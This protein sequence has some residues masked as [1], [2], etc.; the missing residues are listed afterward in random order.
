MGSDSSSDLDSSLSHPP[1]RPSTSAATSPSAAGDS[2]RA[3][4][5][6]TSNFATEHMLTEEKKARAENTR[7]EAKRLAALARSRRKKEEL[8]HSE[9]AQK[10]KELDELL[11]KSSV[12]SDILT[13]KTKALGRV[14]R[15]FDNQTLADAGVELKKQPKIMTG[16][17]M[18]DY[19]LEGLTWMF[20]IML[21]GMSGILADEM[22]LGGFLCYAC[23]RNNTVINNRQAR[24][25]KPFH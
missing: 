25:Y 22:G 6:S 11:R 16:G 24:R 4:M 18:R 8:S 7:N 10:A 2:D 5:G 17:V 13:Q 23:L 21:Q 1:S 12:F 20:E 9:R 19:Q 15:D 14:G 3:K